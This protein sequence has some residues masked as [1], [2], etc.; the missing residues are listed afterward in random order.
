MENSSLVTKEKT[1][2]ENRIWVRIAAACNEKC[3]FCLDADA[4]NGT[5]IW[6][7]IVRK[8]IQ[9]GYKPGEYNRVIISGWEASINPK[10][11]EYIAFAKSIGYDRVQTVTNGN[12]FARKEFCDKVFAAGLDEVT[13]SM[14]WHTA[15]IHDYLTATPWSFQK[16]LRAILTVRKFF[17]HI[18]VNIDIVVCKVNVDFLPEIVR[19][20]MRLGIME[21]DILQIIPFWRWFS[22]YKDQ[23]FYAVEEKIASLHATW[24]LSKTPGMYMW[25]NRFPA[26]A[27]EGY[28]DL[29]QDPRK[30]KSETMGEGYA[31]FDEFIRSSWIKKPLC[32]GE[33]CSVCFLK[34]YCHG[35]LEKHGISEM[36]GRKTHILWK[37]TT[38]IAEAE[39]I[40]L[41]WEEFPSEVYKKYGSSGEEFTQKIQALSLLP[42]QKLVNIPRCIREENNDGLYEWYEDTKHAPNV[43]EYTKQYILN[44]YRKKSTRCI[45]CKYNASC[46]GIHINF[47]RSY[48]FSLLTP[49][50]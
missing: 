13:F 30:I 31:M 18:I 25:T 38:G 27:F 44:F 36:R 46:K 50:K 1:T 37:D 6:E 39:Y 2:R 4:Q 7:D 10:F 22:K 32:F 35:Y 26:E 21:Y 12:M 24:K 43:E 20:F 47:I 41:R 28:E 42:D 11:A 19:F 8:Q 15:S 23:L 5:L 33:Q 14:H 9:E 45:D 29:I 17:P 34:Q 3:L 16:G 40:I 48:G 49:I